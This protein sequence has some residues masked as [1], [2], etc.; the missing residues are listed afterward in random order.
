MQGIAGKVIISFSIAMEPTV[1]ETSEIKI[2]NKI[3]SFT[4]SNFLLKMTK[5]HIWKLFTH[6]CVS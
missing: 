2:T 3:I 6:F 1:W 5:I 4:L